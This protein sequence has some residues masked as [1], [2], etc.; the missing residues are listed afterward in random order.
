MVDGL[1]ALVLAGRVRVGWP[2]IRDYPSI[3]AALERAVGL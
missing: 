2:N 1:Q 3:A